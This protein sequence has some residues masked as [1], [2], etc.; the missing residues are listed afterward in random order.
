MGQMQQLN[1]SQ[2]IHICYQS[3]VVYFD[4]DGQVKTKDWASILLTVQMFKKGSFLVNVNYN[5]H[6]CECIYKLYCYTLINIFIC[7]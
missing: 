3:Q 4:F 6:A 5:Q 2:V 7:W 1:S